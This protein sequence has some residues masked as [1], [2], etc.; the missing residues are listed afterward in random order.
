[1][2]N[3]IST[4]SNRMWY[5]AITVVSAMYYALY[6]NVGF[7]PADD[8]NYAQIAYE[9]YLGT[10]VED[11]TLS[12]GLIWFKLGEILFDLFGPSYLSVKIIF[13]T[14]IAITN[15][16]L[17]YTIV[18]M[19]GRRG[20]ALGMTTVTL[21]VPAFP[22]TAFYSLCILM[23]AAAQMRFVTRMPNNTIQDAVVAGAV[24]SVSFLIRP[25][26][27]YIWTPPLI[28]ILGLSALRSGGFTDFLRLLSA[29]LVGFVAVQ[30][31]AL[32]MAWNSGLLGSVVTPYVSY[33]AMMADY[34]FTGL[35][36]LLPG[37]AQELSSVGATTLQRPPLSALF[38]SET[39]H[40][41]LAILIYAPLLF[42]L[43]GL[44][45]IGTTLIKQRRDVSVQ[46]LA[47]ILVALFAAGAAFPHYFFYRPDLSHVANFMPGYMVLA[48]A[49]IWQ[50]R[51]I[52]R[53]KLAATLA[54]SAIALHLALYV[55]VGVQTQGTGSIAVKASR[56]ETFVAENGVHTSVSAF[57]KQQYEFLRDIILENSAPGDSI[58]CVPYC[59][60]FA[61]M[62]ARRMLFSNFYVDDSTPIN[63]PQWITNAI[64]K[65][66]ADRPPVVIVM[67]W[68][69]NGTKISR[70]ENWAAAYVKFLKENARAQIAKPGFTLYLL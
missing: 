1:M 25:D 46:L 47:K 29:A 50:L 3:S 49:L 65:T 4:R 55:W 40:S 30:V 16:L 34:A 5:A 27:G 10:P 31:P 41:S 36:S 32:L 57:E 48:A 20:L 54:G 45:L 28:L 43:L 42:I 6:L 38:S 66:R 2:S 56:T 61:F 17:F 24:L 62:T 67:D 9:L 37:Y 7:S 70:F 13:F 53:V 23:N 63:D 69:I 26:F 21:I 18:A 22:A 39:G 12:Y 8:G 11:L 35:Q 51:N 14:T 44:G 64:A 68:A 33:P 59:P 58:V 19:T 60:G 52:K 15:V